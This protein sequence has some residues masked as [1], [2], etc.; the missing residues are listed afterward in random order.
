MT[1]VDAARPDGTLAAGNAG[2]QAHVPEATHAE[3]MAVLES[4][5]LAWP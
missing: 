2:G 4:T 5:E 3:M 1:S